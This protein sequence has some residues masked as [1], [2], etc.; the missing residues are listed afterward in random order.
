MSNGKWIGAAAGWFF[1]GPIGGIIGYYVGKNV[2]ASKVD[3]K[4]AFEISLLI[5]SS[6]VIKADGK[7]LKSELEYVKKF[8]TNTFG[9]TKSNEYFRMFNN[10]NKQDYSSKLRQV[11]L[12]LNSHINHSSRLEI[13]HFLFGVSAADNEI[14]PNEVEQ[15]KRI[16]T[17]MN[18]NSYDFESIQ[19]MFLSKGSN[20]EKWYTILGISK[21][22]TDTEVKKAYRKM[23]VK[24]HPDKLIGV[25][26]DIK[27]LAEEKFLVVKESYEQIMKGRK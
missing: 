11:C 20:S 23:A 12:Q 4:T 7:V 25:S 26:D 3:N 18:I 1:A 6:V 27:K 10:L 13:I 24:Y 19:S 8:F 9:T 2:F 16:A 17:Y 14:H 21:D 22:A 15:I 5:L